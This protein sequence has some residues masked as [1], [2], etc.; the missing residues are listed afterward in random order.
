V[1]KPVFVSCVFFLFLSGFASCGAEPAFESFY[2]GLAAREGEAAEARELFLQSLKSPNRFVREAAAAELIGPVLAG[3]VS[4]RRIPK[5]SAG[6]DGGPSVSEITLNAA[7]LYAAG[8]APRR[9]RDIKALLEGITESAA[10]AQALF[11]MNEIR[12]VEAAGEAAPAALRERVFA[13]LSGPSSGAGEAYRWTL[14]GI[15]GRSAFFTEA[16]NAALDGH[17]AAARSSFVEGLEFFRAAAEKDRGLFFRYPEFVSGM[18]RCFQ[19]TGDGGGTELF[20][21][22][23]ESLSAGG[24]AAE[25]VRYR[26]LFFAG[27]I[28]RQLGQLEKAGG[29]FERAFAL[30][31]DTAQADACV[32]YVLDTAL[33]ARAGAGLDAAVA[34]VKTW[35]PRFGDDRTFSDILD[36]LARLLTARRRWKD[37]ADIYALI[38]GRSDSASAAQYAWILGRASARGFFSGGAEPVPAADYFRAVYERGRSSLYYRL[39]SSAVLEKPFLEFPAETP[40]GGPVPVVSEQMEFLLGFFKHGAG[41]FMTAY[42]PGDLSITDTRLLARAAHDA[43]RYADAIRLVASCMEK[44]DY[45][46]HREDFEIAYP[47]PFRDLIERN[48]EENGLPPELLFGLV[49]TES[50]FQADIVSWAGAVGLTQL[51]PATA[52]ETAARIKRQGGPDYA[53]PGA[54]DLRD[55]AVNIHIGAAYLSYL[56]GR[57]ETPLFALLAYNGG[58]TRLRR[59]RSA[60]QDLP[61]DLFLE[62]VEY[63]ETR[64]YGRRV[65]AAAAVY[66]Y[67]YY[68]LKPDA[69]FAGI[70]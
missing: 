19:F 48:A 21:E 15:R 32:W 65:L 61:G 66:G 29:L 13:F 1:L 55:P 45:V 37:I 43:G 53:G 39:L 33:P 27:R 36:R 49:R 14:D 24:A 59:W 64:E 63:A 54:L 28:A 57:L 26:L 41:A 46:P 22:W 58:L 18:G 30:A 7:A 62:T 70:Q 11:L 4:P 31:P 12:F 6:A 60:D 68:D 50:A 69:V 8:Y 40:A 47:R 67:L 3:D 44:V 51:M 56:T 17:T 5:R 2:R 10:W 23:E 42:L 38:Q 34:A 25:G 20:L 52:E 35:I 9:Y 16:E